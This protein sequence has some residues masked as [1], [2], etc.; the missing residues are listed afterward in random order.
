M[1]FNVVLRVL[2]VVLSCLP[3][4]LAATTAE[5]ALAGVT[6]SAGLAIPLQPVSTQAQLDAYVRDTPA[7]RSPLNWLTPGAKKRF[8]NG[9]VF[10]ERG[11]G[12][13]Y[14][15]DLSYELTREQAYT[16]L[17][18][19]GAQ[20]YSLGLDARRT[21][22][23][24][25]ASGEDSALA[26]NYDQL[27]AITHQSDRSADAIAQMYSEH[28]SPE[29]TD[30]QRRTLSDRDV[31]YLFRAATLA[32][33]I[34]HRPAYVDDMRADFS[35]LQRRH[36]IDRPHAN[37][38]YDALIITSK[39]GEARSL[40]ARYPM[41]ERSPAPTMKTASRIPRGK[42]SLWIV[43][44]EQD[45][46]EFV[47]YPFNI[48]ARAQII[49]LASARCHFSEQAARDIEADPA[50]RKAFRGNA[51]WV[52]PASDLT[53]FDAIDAWNETYASSRLG[54]IHDDAELSMVQRIET[55]T[56]YF[57][58]HGRV[59]ATVVGWPPGG[60]IDALRAGLRAINLVR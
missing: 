20:N 44:T 60:N 2:A 49:V 34:D 13:L 28:F 39:P 35:E 12:G 24:A 53:A 57:L 47:R 14:F 59:V 17:S 8:L 42:P 10:H 45:K 5:T 26:V 52:A 43:N 6:R 3:M 22:R 41:I 25:G 27:A 58:D 56:F 48:R 37:D 1:S 4:T 33:Q 38:L 54:V 7:P 19:F 50:L 15:G 18:L 46:R 32:F 51:Q 55:P 9:L 29:Q 30:G 21:P 16:L 40:Q 11:L 23:P 36:L 31:E